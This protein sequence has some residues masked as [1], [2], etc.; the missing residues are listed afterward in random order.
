M[1]T[2][3]TKTIVTSFVLL[4]AFNCFSA[5]LIDKI[6]TT[7]IENWSVCVYFQEAKTLCQNQRTA[8]LQQDFD[9]KVTRFIYQ[10]EFIISSDLQTSTVAIWLDVIDDVDEVRVNG[11]LIGSTGSFPPQFQSGFRYQRLYLI[12]SIILKY[13]QF[14]Q[15]EIQTFSSINASGIKHHPVVIG[16]YFEHAHHGQE[17]DYI[18]IFSIAIFLLLTVF[19][20]F[21]YFLVKGSNE[22]LYL[23]LYL[24]S[25]AVVA[26]T[27][28]QVP[29]HM[30]LDLSSTF[31]IEMFM[32]SVAVGS[33][34]FFAFRFFDL[35][36][37]KTYVVGILA[38][39]LPGLVIIMYPD[40][41]KTRIVAEYGYWI[42]CIVSFF[43]VGSAVV[44]SIFKKRKYS[45]VIGSLCLFG[46]L[47]LC[48]DAIS[49][50]SLFAGLN[51]P[52]KPSLL[53]LAT[54]TVGICMSLA[55]THKY[56]QIFKGATFDYL[57][58]TLLRPAFFQRLSEE[59]QIS[60]QEK[61]MLFVAVINIQEVKKISASY[62]HEVSNNMLLIV[63]DILTK[64]LKPFDLVCHFS[65]DE[66]CIVTRVRSRKEAENYLQ[67]IHNDL[68]TT[69]QVVGNDTE[70]FIDSK[71]G[72]VIY[73]PDQ[74]LSVSQLL[75]DANY[76]LAKAQNQ[77]MK[78]Y[79]LLNNPTVTT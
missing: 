58:G 57:T 36:V 40:P 60:Q 51:F 25:F 3:L 63:S 77:N 24:I 13:N 75:Q 78:D 39:A 70:L 53:L 16:E 15:L 27:R 8:E 28:S 35:E 55:I 44:I 29:L 30:G 31:K 23:S 1:Q 74:H 10:K 12:P 2:K 37:R 64:R 41:L 34:S 17:A 50:S 46:W 59:I 52:L 22:T 9:L 68:S 48:Y 61:S 11:H 42:I 18:Y 32:I 71:L 54:S 67:E 49:Q 79:V 14:N 19:Q 72:G 7:L 73:N 5:Q 66:F 43:T 62:G 56:W 33:F 47:V 69:Q 6:P 21:Y 45:W 20:M 76:G 65:D 26:F 38:M 4:F